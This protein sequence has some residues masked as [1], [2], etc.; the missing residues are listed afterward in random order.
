MVYPG[1]SKIILNYFE[2]LLKA[3]ARH[4]QLK[5]VTVH[6]LRHLF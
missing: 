6:M 4:I 1:G 2:M 5:E 3:Y